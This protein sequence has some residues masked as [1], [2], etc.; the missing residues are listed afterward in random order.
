MTNL[1]ISKIKPNPSGKD[2]NFSGLTSASQLAGEWVDIKNVGSLPVK[3]EGVDLYHLAYAP[4][5]TQGRWAKIAGFKGQLLAGHVLRVHSGPGPESAI[6]PED[7][8][9]AQFHCFTNLDYVWN[10]HQS[11]SPT[12][13]DSE[14]NQI[15]DQASYDPFPPEGDVLIRSGTKLIPVSVLAYTR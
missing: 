15:I 10:N 2:R 14:L 1:Q 12:L 3:L 6:R 7:R 4:G 13:L 5:A 8:D 11:D 9:G